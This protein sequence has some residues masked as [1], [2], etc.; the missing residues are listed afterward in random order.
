MTPLLSVVI[1]THERA[2]YA[3][4]SIH[5]ILAI[6]SGELEVVVSD[7]SSDDG[8]IRAVGLGTAAGGDPRL[9]Y[10][11]P[12][13]PLDMTGNHNFAVA[14][15]RGDFVCLIGDDDSITS[16]LVDAAG[17]ARRNAVR[18]VAPNVVS[19][20]VWPDFRSRFFGAGH[21]ARLYLPR[22]V[23]GASERG[24]TT[25][26]EVA[27]EGAVQG[28]DGLPKIYHGLVSREVLE[29]VRERTGQYFHGSS[30]DVAGAV[31]IAAVLAEEGRNF[32]TVDFPL[33]LPGASG[34]SNTGR[35]AL[36]RHVGRLTDEA[37]TRGFV[38]SGWSGGVPRYFSAE[39]VW[40]HAA[41][42]SLSRLAPTL[43]PRF[44]YA[45]LIGICEVRHRQFSEENTRARAE[46]AAFLGISA[47][48]FSAAVSR[49]KLR[50]L[51]TR[52]RRISRRILMPTAAGGRKYVGRVE[53]IA[54][55]RCVL[56]TYLEQKK[57][58]W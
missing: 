44:N 56:E 47:G 33:T 1:P 12:Q 26:L 37:Q 40:A 38:E 24:A 36:N 6:S 41:I 20:Y 14:Q 18:C 25:A 2:R 35:S 13:Q 45:L 55:A 8:L 30:P 51:A 48:K 46:A 32:H 23:G 15:A 21:A 43:L 28:T 53:N 58:N 22:E 34:G 50:F 3:V 57:W 42:E 5:S 17:W 9:R 7:T 29:K 19:N 49:E 10:L 31:A 52:A 27:L 4:D 54:R 16:H 39:T 11:R